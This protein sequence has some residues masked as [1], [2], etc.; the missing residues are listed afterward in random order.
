MGTP[1][2]FINS[3]AMPGGGGT[4]AKSSS[5]AVGLTPLF[6]TVDLYRASMENARDWLNNFSWYNPLQ[7]QT[8]A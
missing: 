7:I 4:K 2:I 6:H 8:P 1:V 3:P 5:R